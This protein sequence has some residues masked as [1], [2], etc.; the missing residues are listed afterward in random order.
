MANYLK[1]N[2]INIFYHNGT[3]WVFFA[4]TQSSNLQISNSLNAISSKDH[5]IHPDRILSE[6]TFTLSNTCYATTTSLDVIT[7]M[8][9]SAKEYSFCF[10]LVN[11]ATSGQPDADGLSSVTGVGSVASW[12]PGTAW[13][14][15][16]NGVVS[17][18]S[19]ESQT[20]D[21]AQVSLEVTGAGGLASAAQTGDRLKSYSTSAPAQNPQ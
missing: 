2:L 16:G 3:S 12:T 19:V 8:A 21:M 20:G 18:A 9:Q 7:N 10:A 11:E 17:S 4:Y 6:S 5:G 13:V 15:Y 14:R 1:G